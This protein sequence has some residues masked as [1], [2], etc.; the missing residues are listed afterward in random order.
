MITVFI[1][2]I[3]EYL[4]NKLKLQE[5]FQKNF[6]KENFKKENFFEKKIAM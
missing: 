5:N 2:Q 3:R 6:K 1:D 4:T